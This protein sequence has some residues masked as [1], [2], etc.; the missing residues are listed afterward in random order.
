MH[1]FARGWGSALTAVVLAGALS[2]TLACGFS[3]YQK[4]AKMAEARNNLAAIGKSAAAAYERERMPDT[5]AVGQ[6]A[7]V[8]RAL[9]ASA[10]NTVPPSV[11]S[12]R[13]M[14]YMSMPSEWQQGSDS[15]GWKCLKFTIES[16]QYYMYGYT[17][18]G[19]PTASKA[20][21]SFTATA[22]GDLDGD[23]KASTFRLKGQID[24]TLSLNVAPN[25]EETD[26]TE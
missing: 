9:C 7:T 11:S 4:E 14:K 18:T 24:S 1:S 26:P 16:P 12:V 21:D 22:N 13:G 23:G 10:K 3:R 5:L 2:G 19:S 6:A 20:G 17:A 25:I 15:E 8:S